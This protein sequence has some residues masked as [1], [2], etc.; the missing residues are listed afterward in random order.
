VGIRSRVPVARAFRFACFADCL[1]PA[2]LDEGFFISHPLLLAPL[3]TF[4]S[5]PQAGRELGFEGAR[6]RKINVTARQSRI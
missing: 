1:L 5:I 2:V 6:R 3:A 4:G